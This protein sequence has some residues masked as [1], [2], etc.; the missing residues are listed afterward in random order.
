MVVALAVATGI[1][2][3]KA[4]GFSTKVVLTQGLASDTWA[5]YQAKSIK[6]R[7]AE[8][9]ARS[10][11]A[12]DA[13]RGGRRGAAPQNNLMVAEARPRGSRTVRDATAKHGP[14]LGFASRHLRRVALASICLHHQAQAAVGCISGAAGRGGRRL[15]DLRALPGVTFLV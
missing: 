8:M 14:P 13:A 5:F 7:I 11:T 15:R 4:G 3:L 9:E 6:Q 10:A 1:G 12:A 2:S